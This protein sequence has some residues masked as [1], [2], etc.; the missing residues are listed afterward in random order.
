MGEYY[1]SHIL[2]LQQEARQRFDR[3][4]A[5]LTPHAAVHHPHNDKEI[6][7]ING[8]GVR[9]AVDDFKTVLLEIRRLK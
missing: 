5:T 7:N 1:H 9:F 3:L 8:C 2:R 6:V 4:M